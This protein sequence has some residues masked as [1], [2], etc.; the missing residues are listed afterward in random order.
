MQMGGAIST[1][2]KTICAGNLGKYKYK[3][4]Q[5]K[6]S[7]RTAKR[8]CARARELFIRSEKFTGIKVPLQQ[9]LH[10]F[11]SHELCFRKLHLLMPSVATFDI[12]DTRSTHTL[13]RMLNVKLPLV[14]LVPFSNSTTLQITF[15]EIFEI[16]L[17]Y[18]TKMPAPKGNFITLPFVPISNGIML[19]N[20]FSHSSR[21]RKK[22]QPSVVS[23]ARILR[24][25]FEPINQI[26]SPRSPFPNNKNCRFLS[27]IDSVLPSCNAA[28]E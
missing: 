17:N 24:S 10:E 2:I 6:Y 15:F 16:Q 25:K 18:I 5:K 28:V 1:H 27:R 14:K 3:N 21:K 12:E 22:A 19:S 4:A 11:Y 13:P 8:T 9:P 23:G 20:Y 26:P 7:Q